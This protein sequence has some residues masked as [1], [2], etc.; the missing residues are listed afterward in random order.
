MIAG[1]KRTDIVLTAAVVAIRTTGIVK[2]DRV[3]ASNRSRAIAHIDRGTTSAAAR[4]T[5][6]TYMKCGGVART[7]RGLPQYRKLRLQRENRASAYETE[8]KKAF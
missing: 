2:A 1:G 6:K 8:N 5:A 4:E 3:S 7:E